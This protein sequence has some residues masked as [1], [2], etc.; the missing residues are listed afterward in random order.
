MKIIDPVFT[1]DKLKYKIA[2]IKLSMRRKNDLPHVYVIVQ[3]L[4]CS[5]RIE[6]FKCSQLYQKF[7]D[8]DDLLIIGFAQS[9]DAAAEVIADIAERAALNGFSGDVI[10]YLN[11]EIS[12][13]TI[14]DFQWL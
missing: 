7:Y 6:Y 1:T 14:K 13:R 2:D 8:T 9:K 4:R 11:K 3:N 10:Q 12:S 5:G